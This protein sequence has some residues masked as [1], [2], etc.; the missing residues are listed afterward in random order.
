[1]TWKDA[2]VATGDTVKKID[3]ITSC[4]Y[5]CECVHY[6]EYSEKEKHTVEK[7]LFILGTEQK[8]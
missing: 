2:E 1:M 6:I 4:H 3:F 5:A 7:V 8:L